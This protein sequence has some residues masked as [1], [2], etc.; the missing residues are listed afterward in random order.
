MAFKHLRSILESGSEQKPFNRFIDLAK[1]NDLLIKL[2]SDQENHYNFTQH[3]IY[4]TK[5]FILKLTIIFS[6]KTVDKHHQTRFA[7]STNQ[8]RQMYNYIEPI[9]HYLY[10]RDEPRHLFL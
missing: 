10:K 9:Y 8:N 3:Q 5:L 6:I 7:Y 2:H 1:R 4:K